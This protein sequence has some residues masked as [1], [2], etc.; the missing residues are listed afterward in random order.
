[1]GEFTD[2]AI[3]SSAQLR[4]DG[5]TY[6]DIGRAVTQGE[7]I[8]VAHGFYVSEDNPKI[9]LMA[10]ARAYPGIIFTGR[11]A[12]FLYGALP[13]EW[14]ATAEHPTSRTAA[15]R[16]VLRRRTPKPSR[17]VEWLQVSV[18]AKVAVDLS[19]SDE[20]T[21]VRVLEMG[22]SGFK[23]TRRLDEDRAGLTR[24]ERA[25]LAQFLPRAV[26]GTASDLETTAVKVIRRAL[27]EEVASGAVTVETNKLFRGYWFDVMIR[28]ARLLVEIDS[29]AFHGEGKA[30]RSSFVR[31]RHKGNQ[32]T[33]WNWLLLRYADHTVKT[34]PGYVGAEVADTVRFVLAHDRRRREEEALDTDRPVQ[35][36][37]PDV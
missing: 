28:E 21:A 31:D 9:I 16:L 3:W 4:S 13:M 26:L 11:T 23:G 15:T 17:Q 34:V 1:M 33:R 22:Y 24:G 14:P 2:R 36:W 30:R 20:G 19:A 7:L 35:D 25:R 27:A 8:R 5:H 18:P 6:R 12:A 37:Y 29:Y 32:V 10:F